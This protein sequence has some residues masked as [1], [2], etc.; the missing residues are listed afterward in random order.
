MA[1]DILLDVKG[2]S[3]AYGAVQVLENVSLRVRRSE[4]T[5]ILGVNG[6]GKSTLLKALAG[7][8]VK[9]RGEIMLHSDRTDR[10]P[11]HQIQ[12]ISASAWYRKA[13]NYFRP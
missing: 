7:I 4:S 13:G 11:S 1:S 5:S 2:L 6:A 10:L 8:T 3:A 12:R 9:R